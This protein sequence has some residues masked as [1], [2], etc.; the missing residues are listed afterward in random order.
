MTESLGGGGGMKT[1]VITDQNTVYIDEFSDQFWRR[2]E[3]GYDGEQ[4]GENFRFVQQKN[5]RHDHHA[6]FFWRVLEYWSKANT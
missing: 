6:V 2:I 4:K 1:T 3:K 5:R